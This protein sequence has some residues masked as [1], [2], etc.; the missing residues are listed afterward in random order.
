MFIAGLVEYTDVQG[1]II[2]ALLQFLF[3]RVKEFL[4]KEKMLVT[5]ILY[6]FPTIISKD[7][8]LR[9]INSHHFLVKGYFF[10]KS[11]LQHC[12]TVKERK[13]DLKKCV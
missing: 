9:C 1:I 6:L 12:E 11:H 8:F 4:E 2:V 10:F 3:E 7:F 5:Y 13:R